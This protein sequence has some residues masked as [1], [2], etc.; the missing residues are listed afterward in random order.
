MKYKFDSFQKEKEED[1]DSFMH[2]NNLSISNI[3]EIFPLINKNYSSYQSHSGMYGINMNNRIYCIDSNEKFENN[4]EKEKENCKKE[5]ECIC[6]KVYRAIPPIL[7]REEISFIFKNKIGMNGKIQR[8]LNTDLYQKNDIIENVKNH[9]L[10]KDII[11]YKKYNTEKNKF[12]N[13]KKGR[14]RNDDESIRRH[15]KYSPD[16][17]IN[18]IK[19]ILKKYIINF[20]NKIINS[21]YTYQ[22]R[23]SIL[24]ELNFQAD[25]SFELIK[26]VDY[27]LI[28]NKKKKIENLNLLNYSLKEFLSLALSGKYKAITQNKMELLKL[29]EKIMT[30]YLLKDNENKDFFYFIL[31]NLKF[32][33]FLDIFI[34]RK[35]LN[36]FPSFKLLNNNQKNIIEI[37]LERIEV[38]LEKSFKENIDENNGKDNNDYVYFICFLLMI[39]NYRRYFSIKVERNRDKKNNKNH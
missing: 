34:H 21:L 33:D 11:K 27:N 38:F 4:K 39:Y 17:L 6:F 8:I 16:N 10:D 26:D 18:K 24:S 9:L 32:E 1:F 25:K 31:N 3:E 36:D 29:N 37:S 23:I 5:K 22:K 30:E 13:K 2:N 14:K 15:N 20:V 7:L 12:I 28:A 35:E 19:T